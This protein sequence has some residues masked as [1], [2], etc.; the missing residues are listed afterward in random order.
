MQQAQQQMQP[1]QDQMQ[2]AQQK[3]QPLQQQMQQLQQKIQP[4][5]LQFQQA[6][7]QQLQQT[8][9]QLQ[10]TQQQLQQ[11]QQQLQQAQQ[12]LAAMGR[13][14]PLQPTN[15][16]LRKPTTSSSIYKATEAVDRGASGE[17]SKAVDGNTS[18]LFSQNSM[19]LTNLGPNQFWQVD[20]AGNFKIS[21]IR[22]FN[23][24]DCC[25][26]R[27]VGATLQILGQD[28]KVVAQTMINQSSPAYDIPIAQM[29]S[30]TGGV[31]RFVRI[32]SAAKADN[33]LQLAEVEV[34]GI[35]N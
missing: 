23:R 3:M 5:Q 25:S 28:G 19:A 4:I 1:L 8:Q 18:Q 17:P 31:G 27:I 7:Q 13:P 22:I 24:T 35:P 32:I 12:Q 9:Q 34:Y 16:A 21:N 6:Q 33:Y 29:A 20:L 2:Q 26:E 10:Q 30:T 15:V 11:T 14:S